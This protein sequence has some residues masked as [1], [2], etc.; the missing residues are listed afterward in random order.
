MFEQLLN[1]FNISGIHKIALVVNMASQVL[2][3]IE[4]EFGVDPNA[5]NSAIDA[6][7][8]LLQ[9]QK[10]APAPAPGPTTPVNPPPSSP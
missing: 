3:N 6:M 10:A 1:L 9:R 7:I 8:A 2:Q 5:K 4:K